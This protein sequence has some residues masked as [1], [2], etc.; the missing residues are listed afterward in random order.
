MYRT[1]FSPTFSRLL[2]EEAQRGKKVHVTAPILPSFDALEIERRIKVKLKTKVR[3]GR[4]AANHNT[5]VR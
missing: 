3:A 4:I 5:P 2:A 1:A